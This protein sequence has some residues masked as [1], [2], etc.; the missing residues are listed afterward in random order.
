MPTNS[1]PRLTK[2]EC[3]RIVGIRA[4]QLGM[5]APMLIDVP[6][7]MQHNFLYVAASELK[8][9][10]LDVIIHRPLPLNKSYEVN[11]TDLELPD[12]IDTVIAMYKT[13]SQA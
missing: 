5:S 8:A 12:D 7:D 2:Y 13:N 11:V 1:R 6:A 9:G 4:A 3:A 10:V